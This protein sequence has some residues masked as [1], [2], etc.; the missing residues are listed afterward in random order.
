MSAIAAEHDGLPLNMEH[1]AVLQRRLPT[2]PARPVSPTRWLQKT[3]G[4][5]E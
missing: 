1:C 3:G 5:H 4:H 2:L